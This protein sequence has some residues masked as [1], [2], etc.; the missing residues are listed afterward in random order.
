MDGRL[1]SRLPRLRGQRTTT[2]TYRTFLRSARNWEEFANNAKI[3]Q[4]TGLTHEEARAACQRFND[5]RTD[6]DIDRGTKMEFERE[7]D[8][9]P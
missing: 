8:D 3:E 4:Q 1:S 9:E 6:V 5:F 2:M 7:S